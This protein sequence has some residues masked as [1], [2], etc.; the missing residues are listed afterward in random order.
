VKVFNRLV[1]SALLGAAASV[2]AATPAQDVAALAAGAPDYDYTASWAAGPAGPGPVAALPPGASPASTAPGVDVFYVHPTTYREAGKWN[3]DPANAE[4][5]RW[6]DESVMARQASA[7]SGCCRVWAPRYRAA[8]SGAL[9]DDAHR[10]P[11]FAL[12]YGDVERA[13]DWFL[14]H[15]GKDRPF[16]IAGHSQGAKHVSDLLERRIDGS[17]ALRARMVAA[18]IVGINL[19]EGGFGLRY[20]HV[21]VCD[22]PDQTGCALQWN[23]IEAGAD[24]KQLAARYEQAFAATHP[25]AAG[26]QT[27]CVN[28]VTFDRRQPFSL[29]SQAKGAVPGNPGFGPMQPLRAGAVAVRCESGFAVS[30]QAP[31]LGLKALP[32]G[33][34]HFHDFGLFWADIRA[35][36]VLRSKVWLATHHR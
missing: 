34:L 22:R 29:S 21:P 23:A 16:M 5:N 9:M 13:F 6:T 3:Q 2:Q 36:A 7:F 30:Y 28:P 19:A 27:L 25:Q 14:A 12:A 35:N 1:G 10:D 18:Y 32:G 24:L 33:L 4:Q 20:R 15:I 11:A 8:S 17:P 26:R 31:G